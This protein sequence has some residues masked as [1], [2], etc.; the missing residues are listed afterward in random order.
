MYLSYTSVVEP[1]TDVEVESVRDPEDVKVIAAAVGGNLLTGDED[2][3]TLQR[4][5]DVLI[6][7]PANFLGIIADADER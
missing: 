7:S 1:A 4:F 5:E 2:L 3:L 6:V